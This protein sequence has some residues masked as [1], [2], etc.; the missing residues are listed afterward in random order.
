MVL[1]STNE[2]GRQIVMA[3]PNSS[4]LCI[5]HC[6]WVSKCA[7]KNKMCRSRLRPARSVNTPVAERVNTFPP[8]TVVEGRVFTLVRD[9]KSHSHATY[10]TDWRGPGQEH[11]R[12]GRNARAQALSAS[13]QG[14][15]YGAASCRRSEP[16]AAHTAQARGVN[17]V[18][19]HLLFL[20][21]QPQTRQVINHCGRHRAH[22]PATATPSA[23]QPR[24]RPLRCVSLQA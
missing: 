9:G 19:S 6:R 13:R 5:C 8:A 14:H 7:H 11:R 1:T 24:V 18:R 23:A 21:V 15:R 2:A 3:P 17:D 10:K 16:A 4:H 20:V 22:S 12:A